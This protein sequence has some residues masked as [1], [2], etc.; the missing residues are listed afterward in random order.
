[1]F[2]RNFW[3]V[4]GWDG[5]IGRTPVARTICNENVVLYRRADRS[6]VALEDSCPHR[7]LP[8]SQGYVEGDRLV[9]GYHGLEF[10]GNGACVHMPNQQSIHP[11]ACVRAYPVVEKD[12]FVWVWIGDKE[13]AD[14]ALVPEIPHASEEGWVFDG[15]TYDVK[16]G[17]ELLVD[18][19]MDLSHE[20]YVHP[21]SIGQL[22]ITESLPQT[23]SD[24]ESVTVERWMENIVPPPFWAN[25]LKSKEV[26]DRWQICTFTLP[27]NVMIDVGV[28]LAGTGAQQGDRSKGVTGIVVNCM[29]PETET[30]CRYYWGMVRNFDIDDNGLTQNIKDAQAKVFY[31]DLEVVEG[32]QANM[33]RHPERKLLNFNIDAGGVR[34]RRL[35]DRALAAAAE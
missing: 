18:N 28:A 17:Y 29:T 34:A 4:A 2:L 19:L 16:C 35:I 10:D 23:R 3:Y 14:E 9:C 5:E 26:C 1:M 25:N 22:E 20:T 27:S 11:E 24:D 32:Q 31:E 30:T 21:S 12:R 6:L 8:L 15:G 13:K 7:L 33:L